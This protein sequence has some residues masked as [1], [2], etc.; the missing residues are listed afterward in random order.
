M[1]ILSQS[2][3]T[4]LNKYNASLD[5]Y[6]YSDLSGATTNDGWIHTKGD[7]VHVQTRVGT[8]NATSVTFRIEGRSNG[9][10]KSASLAIVNVTAA[11]EIDHVTTITPKFGEIRVG[12][13]ID[14]SAEPNLVYV[15]LLRTE[16]H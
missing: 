12:V 7:H 2:A 11:Q 15:G 14:K 6:V 10:T 1:T 16:I 9:Y 3:R 4:L 8:L 13:K 5:T